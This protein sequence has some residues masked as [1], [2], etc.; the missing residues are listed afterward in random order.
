MLSK[1]QV[2]SDTAKLQAASDL[3]TFG[4][5][6]CSGTSLRVL[7]NVL[8]LDDGLLLERSLFVIL[9]VVAVAGDLALLVGLALGALGLGGSLLSGS[10]GGRGVG[11]CNSAV[12]ASNGS[13]EVKE[14]LLGD[15]QHLASRV[16]GFGAGELRELFVVNLCDEGRACQFKS[17]V[18]NDW[19]YSQENCTTL[20]CRHSTRA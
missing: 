3:S 19:P 6:T 14:L 12:G 20:H 16:G 11:R 17:L 10:L 8:V 4:I 1:P 15:A 13:V 7:I 2:F 5:G 18:N 9:I